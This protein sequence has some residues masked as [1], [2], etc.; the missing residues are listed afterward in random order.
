MVLGIAGGNV[1]NVEF[2]T[3][4]NRTTDGDY[5]LTGGNG[6]NIYIARLR[7]AVKFANDWYEFEIPVK[8]TVVYGT[9]L[10]N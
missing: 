5:T 10:Y 6:Q 2:V 4:G 3:E 9:N 7:Y 1:I 8:R